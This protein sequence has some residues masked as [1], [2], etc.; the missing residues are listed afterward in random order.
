[1]T[2]EKKNIYI[3]FFNSHQDFPYSPMVH[4]TPNFPIPLKHAERDQI[5]AKWLEKSLFPDVRVE[6][7]AEAYS[8]FDPVSMNC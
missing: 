6:E 7:P 3:Y 8:Q 1:M 2:F 5:D 4:I